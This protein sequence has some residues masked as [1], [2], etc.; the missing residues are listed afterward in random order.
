MLEAL[1]PSVICRLYT[2]GSPTTGV[3]WD[4]FGVAAAAF[5]AIAVVRAPAADPS[6]DDGNVMVVR[7]TLLALAIFVISNTVAA[8]FLSWG[9]TAFVIASSGLYAAISLFDFAMPF[10]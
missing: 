8:W 10:S 1:L 4:K 5:A 9:T 2:P 3:S 6:V 7:G